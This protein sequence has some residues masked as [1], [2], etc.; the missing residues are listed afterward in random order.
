MLYELKWVKTNYIQNYRKTFIKKKKKTVYSLK[1]KC[2]FLFKTYQIKLSEVY[3]FD[4]H[5]N[6]I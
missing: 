2:F 4:N 3:L 1:K 5:K 6:K